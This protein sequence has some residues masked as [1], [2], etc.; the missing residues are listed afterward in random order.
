MLCYNFLPHL[1]H[2][3]GGSKA[4]VPLVASTAT[5]ALGHLASSWINSRLQSWAEKSI[6]DKG[7][8]TVA[9]SGQRSGASPST[10]AQMESVT[11][12]KENKSDSKVVKK[13]AWDMW[14]T[15]AAAVAAAMKAVKEAQQ[16]VHVCSDSSKT[17]AA[18]TKRDK[19]SEETFVSD[20]QSEVVRVMSLPHS[21]SQT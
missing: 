17:E 6:Q 11:C 10:A 4:E 9:S 20:T 8:A 14:T 18:A 1:N 13:G 16:H 15:G 7:A 3:L 5:A 21:F 12:G 19:Q 2:H